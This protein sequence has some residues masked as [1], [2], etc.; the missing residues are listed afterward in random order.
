M[1]SVRA[2]LFLPFLLTVVGSW[3]QDQ[4]LCAGAAQSSQCVQRFEELHRQ[5]IDLKAKLAMGSK[6][7]T[8]DQQDK[9]ANRALWDFENWGY[10]AKPDADFVGHYNAALDRC[11]I[12]TQNTLSNGEF[13]WRDLCDAY[14]GEQYG[15]YG[16]QRK[17]K[18]KYWDVPPFV[19]HVIVPS[20]E[21]RFCQSEDE[22]KKLAMAY[23]GG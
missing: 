13:F 22:F 5:I 23:M 19:C 11:F 10:K 17:D 12:Q 6:E 9:C 15:Q 20:G 18:Q 14:S 7:S 1:R 21:K 16:W 4:K 3:G 2:F 8:L